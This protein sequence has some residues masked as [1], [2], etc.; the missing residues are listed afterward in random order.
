MKGVLASVVI[1]IALSSPVLAQNVQHDD[2]NGTGN[3]HGH[4]VGAPAPL[5]GAG[6]PGIATCLG[7]G[8]YWL[9]RRRRNV[10]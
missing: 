8:M 1:V 3:G 2:H 7:L 4:A 10:G 9:V 5:L 6:I